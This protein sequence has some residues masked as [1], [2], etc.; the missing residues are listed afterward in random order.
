MNIHPGR[1]KSII[2]DEERG[3]VVAGCKEHI[4][5][6]NR[7][8][9][10]ILC[11]SPR[12]KI[13]KENRIPGS[14]DDVILSRFDEMLIVHIADSLGWESFPNGESRFVIANIP[15]TVRYNDL[16]GRK[17]SE[18]IDIPCLRPLDLE[19]TK[20]GPCHWGG[21]FIWVNGPAPGLDPSYP[22]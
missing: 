18:I 11:L 9:H 16:S 17:L 10:G 13:L 2:Y 12:H 20:S 19:I 14:Y 6:D 22:I 1:L 8:D 15:D 21:S 5:S 4:N 3:I 7:N